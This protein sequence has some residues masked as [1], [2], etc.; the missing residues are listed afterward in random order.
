MST[1]IKSKKLQPIEA[2]KHPLAGIKHKFSLIAGAFVPVGAEYLVLGY[3]PEPNGD[4]SLKH[5]FE[6]ISKDG[7]LGLLPIAFPE[8]KCLQVRLS[9]L[10]IAADVSN[11]LTDY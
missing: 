11:V 4:T 8:Y 3:F 2:Y 5:Y 10:G 7:G 1:S 9:P 6:F